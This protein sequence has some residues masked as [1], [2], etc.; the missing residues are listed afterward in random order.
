VDTELPSDKEIIDL[1]EEDAWK[2][3][4]EV[5]NAIDINEVDS[6]IR[7]EGPQK[8]KWHCRYRAKLSVP[9]DLKAFPFDS[10]QLP[11]IVRIP[12]AADRSHIS[13]LKLDEKRAPVREGM[14]LMTPIVLPEWTIHQPGCQILANDFKVK[15]TVPVRR[16]PNYYLTNIYKM[17]FLFTFLSLIVFLLDLKDLPDRVNMLLTLMLTLIAFKFAVQDS[18]PTTSYETLLDTYVLRCFE[19]MFGVGIEAAVVYFIRSR[20]KPL[21]YELDSLS[22]VVSIVYF[23]GLH[24][25]YYNRVQD[26]NSRTVKSLP[27]LATF[28]DEDKART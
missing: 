21:A 12:R 1:S 6:G 22:A 26:W 4:I 20:S 19:L 9:L 13:A 23:L 16:L 5:S 10:H 18:L 24:Y 3:F 15:I 8:V 2:P 11:I 7:T 17:M 27:P 14:A 28:I 25:W